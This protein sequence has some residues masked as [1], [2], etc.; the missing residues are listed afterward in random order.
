[1]RSKGAFVPSGA[2]E[3]GKDKYDITLYVARARHLGHILPA[4]L[5][6]IQSAAYSSWQGKELV[7]EQYEVSLFL[8]I[9]LHYKL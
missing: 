3:A 2:V 4:S 1:V 5:N 7:Q 8:I 9:L 6:P